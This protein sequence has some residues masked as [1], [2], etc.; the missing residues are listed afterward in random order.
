MFS[1]FLFLVLFFVLTS[2]S[3]LS[4]IIFAAVSL[5]FCWSDCLCVSFR[6]SL[7]HSFLYLLWLVSF[8]F[9]NTASV[10]ILYISFEASLLPL[11]LLIVLFGYQPEKL[12]ASLYLLAYTV[13]GSLPLLLVVCYSLHFGIFDLW[14]LPPYKTL[15]VSLAFLIKSPLYLVHSWLPKAH[16]EAPL[17]G[18]IVLAGVMLKFGGYGILLLAPSFS[19]VAWVYAY[20]TLLGSISCAILCLRHWDTKS[21]VAYSSVVHIGVV[22]LGVLLG[23]E[24]GWFSSVSI[25]VRHRL[26]SPLLF[27]AC[28]ALYSLRHRRSLVLNFLSAV[29]STLTT[30]AALLLSINIGTPPFLSFW[31]EVSLYLALTDN[32]LFGSIV[33]GLVSFL[34]FAFSFCIFLCCF[35]CSKVLTPSSP[36]PLFLFLPG[37]IFSLFG[38]LCLSVFSL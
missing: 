24:I 5:V 13:L 28:Y 21:L 15:L 4:I 8:V 22:T 3:P 31:V 38:S 10:L 7:Q 14:L 18:S 26:V 23:T 27:L 9:F 19:G 2:S 1:S 37:I 11:V 36:F 25:I 16:T 17:L 32:F 29:T 33:L 20:I 35:S 34:V 6:S 30:F 12:Q